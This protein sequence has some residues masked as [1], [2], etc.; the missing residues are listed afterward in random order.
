MKKYTIW[1]FAA[2]ISF[3]AVLSCAKEES[4]NNFEDPENN[5]AGEQVTI[6]AS[7]SPALTKVVFDP[8]YT[9]DKP[10][11]LS[12]TWK[13]SDKLRVA[14]HANSSS[15]VDFDL[16]S[17]AG[18]QSAVFTGTAPV[19]ATSYD[20]SIVNG[21]VAAGQAADGTTTHLQY[22]A[23]KEDI[24]DLTSVAFDT[25]N[26]IL[27]I[28]AKMP[29][30]VAA[31]IKSVDITAYQSDGTTP[32][33]IFN[34][35]NTLSITFGTIGDEGA[36]NVLHFFAT[37]PQ[38]D[39]EVAAG[40]KL[41]VHFN[42]PGTA[43]TVYTRFIELGATTFT[44]SK[45]N[46]I[47]INAVNSASY[48]NASTTNIGQ[49]TNPY[50]I[51]DKYQLAAIALTTTKQYYKL[52]DDIDMN[53]ESWTSL[54][55]EGT[56]IID[57]NGNG[58]KISNLTAPLFADLNGKVTNLTLFNSVVTSSNTVGL[59][60]NTVNTAA[61]EVSGVTITGSSTLT[62]TPTDATKYMG[63][64]VG[65][66]STASTFDNCL[67]ESSTIAA[68]NNK[69]YAGGAFG[70]VH[71][72]GAK[73]GY[74]TKCT[75]ASTTT[76]SGV[77]N[78]GGFIGVLDG[79]TVNKNE[80]ACAVSGGSKV[81]GF[82]GNLKSGSMTGDYTTGN[83]TSTYQ[84]VGGLIGLMEGG[85]VTNC[86]ADG[87]VSH[88]Y[89]ASYALIGG[90]IG[91][92]S[93]GAVSGSHASGKVTLQN[94]GTHVGGFIGKIGG[95]VTITQCYAIGVVEGKGGL[96]GF[97]GIMEGNGNQTISEC[98][99][100]GNFKPGDDGSG[101]F[102][103]KIQ[104]S[105]TGS[106][107]IHD[108][109]STG[110]AT[111]NA[112]QCGSFVGQITKSAGTTT[113]SNCYATG[114]N[115]AGY[116]YGHGGFAGKIEVSNATIQKCAAWTSQVK[117]QTSIDK[118]SAGTIVGVAHPLCT[119]TDNYRNPSMTLH[120]YWGTAGNTHTLTT[121][122]QHRNVSSS[123][124]LM[125]INSEGTVAETTKT[126]LDTT[127]G[128]AIFAYQGKCVAG[129]T[130]SQLAS[131]TSYLNWGTSYWDYEQTLPRLKWTLPTE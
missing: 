129:Q 59:L 43:H 2:A 117:G 34:A 53:G 9:A 94:T 54:N 61:S 23:S 47:N 45:L 90:L 113:I 29:S 122:F 56:K 118:W 97:I 93:G 100:T 84:T 21:D 40:T 49:S 69:A 51:G 31:V 66:V 89:K 124:P 14:D 131:S 19:G 105:G 125:T 127:D 95:A 68:S 119:L 64:L 130:L 85:T 24:T 55:A 71:N 65:E 115:G 111:A 32:A 41:L 70:Y 99:A 50:L 110:N 52:V 121:D 92:M 62:C 123:P 48:A 74:T 22:L 7:I 76:F 1:A 11:S 17:G 15:Y 87:D 57:L 12:L 106:F 98:Y 82:V 63:G 60:A 30:D 102:I 26:S 25:F 10:S 37:L 28:T 112:S 16:T 13:S 72:A 75:V 80:V 67:I 91:N 86:Y 8:T 42:A 35:G 20:V 73:I 79:G 18:G 39:Q 44:N 114:T 33:N 4:I 46:T 116:G 58:K 104:G 27:A 108:C 77:D 83:V 78:V 81:G 107:S 120:A 38:G 6:N 3:A 36:D 126:S 96:G 128:N 101:G 88:N 103:G 109:Y 5:L